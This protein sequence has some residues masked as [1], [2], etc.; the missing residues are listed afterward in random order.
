VVEI[1]VRHDQQIDVR[2][3]SQRGDAPAKVVAP[4]ARD[5]AIDQDAPWIFR[6]SIFDPQRIAPL[7]GKYVDGENRAQSGP[8]CS[9]STVNNFP[10][11]VM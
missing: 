2:S 5:T 4:G 8:A 9:R 7:R 1:D 11:T 3:R 6:S 10:G